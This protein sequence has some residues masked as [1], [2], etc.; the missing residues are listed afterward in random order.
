VLCGGGARLPSA[1]AKT[2]GWAFSASSSGSTSPARPAARCV[3]NANATV[4]SWPASSTGRGQH[5][6]G[7]ERRRPE[8]LGFSYRHSNLRAGEVISRAS[9]RLRR[10]DPAA[11]RRPWRRCANGAATPSPRDQDLR[12][13]LQEPESARAEAARRPAARPPPAAAA[14]A[15]GARFSESTQL[16][17]EFDA[18]TSTDVLELMARAGGG[19]TERFGVELEPEVQVAGRSPLAHWLGAVS[20][21]WRR[22]SSSSRR[23]SPPTSS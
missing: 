4:V 6:A 14:W 11:I 8:Q 7:T 2:A 20:A 10:G 1:A 16:R 18:A 17:R 19:S 5:G 9:F 22:S 12:L 3:M 21:G 13:D 23:R 15:M